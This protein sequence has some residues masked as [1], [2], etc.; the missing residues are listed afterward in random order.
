[1]GDARDQHIVPCAP[2]PYLPHTCAWTLDSW[3]IWKPRSILLVWSRLQQINI[4]DKSSKT[5]IRES[6]LFLANPLLLQVVSRQSLSESLNRPGYWSGASHHSPRVW[7]RACCSW[8]RR[9]KIPFESTHPPMTN[10]YS[11]ELLSVIKSLFDKRYRA[12]TSYSNRGQGRLNNLAF[13]G[14]SLFMWW[15]GLMDN[16]GETGTLFVEAS[17]RQASKAVN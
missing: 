3:A 16:Q 6:Q 15:P 11:L 1:M 14:G 10:Q 17:V 5:S 2:S 8:A 12:Y 4:L 13:F 9:C 7:D